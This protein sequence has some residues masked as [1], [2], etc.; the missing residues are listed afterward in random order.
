MT[1]MLRGV[2]VD[3]GDCPKLKVSL[4]YGRS[5]IREE[6]PEIA[7]I[8]I[9]RPKRWGKTSE[10]NLVKSTL[11]RPHG[12][13]RLRELARHKHTPVIVTCDKT[14][15]VPSQITLPFILEELQAAG[16]NKNSVKV[17]VATGL[18]KGETLNDVKERLGSELVEILDVT[19]HD[20]D[21][22]DQ[23]SYL[24]DLPSGTP[25]FLNTAVVKSDLVIV[26]G[27][28]EPHFFAGF[29]GGA[30]VI[31][32]GVAGTETILRNHCWQNIDNPQSRYGVA[33]NPVRAD[34]NE[35]LRYI[36]QTF[37]LNLILNSQKRMV[38]ATCGDIVSSFNVAAEEMVR[39]SEIA[40]QSPPDIMITTNGG[41]PLDRNVY[42]CVKGIAVAEEVVRE[43]SRIIMTGECIDGV[44]HEHFEETL[45][46]DSPDVISERL[47]KANV[48]SRDQWEVQVLCRVMQ[49]CPIWFVTRPELASSI[50]S[51]HMRYASGVNEALKAAGLCE[52]E[53]VLVVPNGPSTILRIG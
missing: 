5:I 16:V 8:E 27:T 31:L 44:S 49:K 15:G 2:V 4:P 53:R 45:R 24:G 14:R 39:H 1:L 22:K 40:V 3:L 20:S 32:P 9:A 26:E 11:K 29:T 23:L 38:H 43:G 42:Q 36:G 17:L 10:P 12:L 6:I 19:I 52:G 30:K 28:I 7:T 37:A 18:H 25:L 33:D 51:M 35:S 21:D 50:E 48:T 46:T 47:K 34:A 13:P 41:Y